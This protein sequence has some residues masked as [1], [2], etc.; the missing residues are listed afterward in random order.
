MAVQVGAAM[1]G[2]VGS[3]GGPLFDQSQMLAMHN[4]RFEIRKS[5]VGQTLIA[6]GNN[7]TRPIVIQLDP[8]VADDFLATLARG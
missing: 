5:D 4:P 6:F 2:C 3:Q 8:G 1:I 7:D